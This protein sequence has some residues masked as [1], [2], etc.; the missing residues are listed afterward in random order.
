MTDWYEDAKNESEK[1]D[2][3]AFAVRN[4]IEKLYEEL[5]TEIA[6]QIADLGKKHNRYLYTNGGGFD[7]VIGAPNPANMPT[8]RNKKNELHVR[9]AGDKITTSGPCKSLEFAAWTGPDNVVRLAHNGVPKTM[10]EAAIMVLRG[11]LFLNL[12]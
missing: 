8:D 6:Q 7:R 2:R 12:D 11:F 1:R 10:Q 3:S 9:L 4:N 5:W